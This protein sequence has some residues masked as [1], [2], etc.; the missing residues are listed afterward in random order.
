[1][2]FILTFHVEGFF[3]KLECEMMYVRQ[4]SKYGIYGGDNPYCLN[5]FNLKDMREIEIERFGIY[6]DLNL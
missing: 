4:C 5:K 3:K 2:I 6:Y 1:M